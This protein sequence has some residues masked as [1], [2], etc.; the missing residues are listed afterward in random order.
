MTP[1]SSTKDRRAGEEASKPLSPKQLVIFAFVRRFIR[2]SGVSP[3]F[4]EV[5]DGNPELTPDSLTYNLRVLQQRKYL[6]VKRHGGVSLVHLGEKAKKELELWRLV[7]E[8]L[9][10]WSGGK[11]KGSS[12]PIEITSGP[13]ISDFI[14]QMR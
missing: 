9:A 1:K 6:Q 11:P 5:R 12:P 14:H 8:G 10:L 7:D 2:D 4:A 13:P 3:T